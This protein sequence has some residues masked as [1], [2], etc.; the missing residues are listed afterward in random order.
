M[1]TDSHRTVQDTLNLVDAMMLRNR[2]SSSSFALKESPSSSP[3][4][5][6]V[7]EKL[8]APEGYAKQDADEAGADETG[9]LAE[10]QPSSFAFMPVEL[11]EASTKETEW[12]LPSA[13]APTLAEEPD[14]PD[15]QPQHAEVQ[16][17]VL[18]PVVDM[19]APAGADAPGREQPVATTTPAPK[20][21]SPGSAAFEASLVASE[22]EEKD[23][24]KEPPQLPPLRFSAASVLADVLKRERKIQ[25]LKNDV[26]ELEKT[27]LQSSSVSG[28]AEEISE[29]TITA[30]QRTKA[31]QESITT[32][33]QEKSRQP[34]GKPLSTDDD[35]YPVLTDVVEEGDSYISDFDTA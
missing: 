23:I 17:E 19:G 6:D 7:D 30:Q 24:R 12:R 25:A 22:E 13:H 31:K 14:E 33:A 21:P 27:V 15:E 16:Q 9:R 32:I 2:R 29:E 8:T 26:M 3:T 28:Q 11:E 18:T 34:G 35:D 20:E 1:P 5:D 4:I 10:A